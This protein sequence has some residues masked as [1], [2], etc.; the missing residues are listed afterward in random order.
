MGN[1]KSVLFSE[2]PDFW[3]DSGYSS[4]LH[5]SS[6]HPNSERSHDFFALT[7]FSHSRP[8]CRRCRCYMARI[9]NEAEVEVEVESKEADALDWPTYGVIF[10]LGIGMLFPWNAIVLA[11]VRCSQ[12]ALRELVGKG[13][14]TGVHA[15]RV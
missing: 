14:A 11:Y 8:S 13:G 3:I 2:R 4:T 6:P 7:L 12:E 15:G 10:L 9:A 5:S 1:S